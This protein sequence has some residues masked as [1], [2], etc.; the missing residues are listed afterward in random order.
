MQIDAISNISYINTAL[1]IQTVS[2]PLKRRL[3]KLGIKAEEVKNDEEAKA[4]LAEKE[5]TNAAEDVSETD[6]IQNSAQE[7]NFYDRELMNDIKLLASDLGM[8]VSEDIDMED[9]LYNISVK[10]SQIQALFEGNDNLKKV[11]EQ[12]D[13]RYQNIYARYLSKKNSLSTQIVV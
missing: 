1:A 12:F 8:Y 3:A 7:L 4:I 5:Q 9:L 10:I 13:D 6:K 2:A 11:A